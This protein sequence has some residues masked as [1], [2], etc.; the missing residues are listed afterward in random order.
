MK[1][2]VNKLKCAGKPT[3]M[4]KNFACTRVLM[5]GYC[6][7]VL[8]LFASGSE[9]NFHWTH[10]A[11]N[12]VSSAREFYAGDQWYNSGGDR[13]WLA[14]EVNSFFPNSHKRNVYCQ[15]SSL[16]PENYELKKTARGFLLT[17]R[18]TIRFLSELKIEKEFSPARNPLRHERGFNLEGVEYRL[19]ATYVAGTHWQQ[20][21]NKRT[22]GPLESGSNAAWRGF[23]DSHLWPN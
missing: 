10:L 20:P 11:R 9:E 2:L 23:V 15:Q 21:E 3:R 13:T 14:P 7:R 5:L 4:F 6:G 1:G 8:G 19:H 22:S 18:F 16:A 17:K 12:S